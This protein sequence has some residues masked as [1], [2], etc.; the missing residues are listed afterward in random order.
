M[1]PFSRM[2]AY[3]FRY[4][5]NETI[6]HWAGMIHRDIR[7][8]RPLVRNTCYEGVIDSKSGRKSLL[9]CVQL[10]GNHATYATAA[11]NLVRGSRQKTI[12]ARL[13]GAIPAPLELSILSHN[14][15]VLTR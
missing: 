4:R 14:S 8:G 3:Y 1:G 7:Q 2:R 12:L 13:H 9:S 11:R 5:A 10:S 15:P 6:Q